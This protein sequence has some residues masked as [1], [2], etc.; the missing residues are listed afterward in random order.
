M[1]K[2]TI[3]NKTNAARLD[4]SAAAMYLTSLNSEAGRRTMAQALNVCAGLM[5][6]NADALAFAW[7]ELRFQHVTAIRAKLNEVYK[8]A[9]VNKMLAAL[10]G[11]LRC[12]WQ[13]GHMS[14]EDFHKAASVKSVKGE[15]LPAGRE[16]SQGELTALMATCE[17]DTTNAG[18]RDAAII[19]LMYSCGLRREE[20]V[21]LDLADFEPESGRLVVRG[22][23]NKERTA[24]LTGGA[25]RAVADWLAVRGG[26][27]G[28][29]FVA[30]NKSGR[31]ANCEHMTPKTIY[32]M[33]AKR[34]T[35]AGVKSFSPH[36]MRRT[37]VSDLLD[38]GAD[39]TT[40][41][42]M[43]GHANVTTTSRYDRRP[44]E[45]KRKAASLLHVPYAGRG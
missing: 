40:V 19:G 17:Q 22:K 43:A 13:A 29:L 1:N 7:H 37:F 2:L 15:T 31:M 25:A 32:S 38:A 44:E 20:V 14:A 42:K 9:T 24:W 3:A 6:D 16:L 45:A 39:I 11:V 33:L 23:G 28:A 34:A 35:E 10:R 12:A 8:P 4:Q 36:D 5:S 41:S 30:V 27:V 26:E 18:A 21:T